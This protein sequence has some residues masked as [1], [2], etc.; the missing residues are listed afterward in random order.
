[1]SQIEKDMPVRALFSVP[2]ALLVMGLALIGLQMGEMLILFADRSNGCSGFACLGA[3]LR[4]SYSWLYMARVLLAVA[5]VLV[6]VTSVRQ[7]HRRGNGSTASRLWPLYFLLILGV[8]LVACVYVDQWMALPQQL[9]GAGHAGQTPPSLGVEMLYLF[10]YTPPLPEIMVALAGWL[11][12]SRLCFSAAKAPRSRSG[13]ALLFALVFAAVSTTVFSWLDI[14]LKLFSGSDYILMAGEYRKMTGVDTGWGIVLGC[15]VLSLPVWAVAYWRD[16]GGRGTRGT[17][18]AA[19]IALILSL[20]SGL[21][22]LIATVVYGG[23]IRGPHDLVRIAREL[24]LAGLVGNALITW[25]S[26]A[27]VRPSA[28]GMLSLANIFR[29]IA[30]AGSVAV[31]AVTLGFVGLVIAAKLNLAGAQPPRH[32]VASQPLLAQSSSPDDGHCASVV[33]A[34]DALWLVGHDDELD[35]IEKVVEDPSAWNLAAGPGHVE[36]QPRPFRT[37]Y[38]GKTVLSRLAPD[39]RFKPVVYFPGRGCLVPVPD[40]DSVLLFTTLRHRGTSSVGNV[41]GTIFQTSDG[42]AHWQEIAGGMFAT[43]SPDV[44]RLGVDYRSAHRVWAWRT[45]YANAGEGALDFG[46]SSDGG[47]TA[48]TL[49]IPDDFRSAAADVAASVPA[50]GRPTLKRDEDYDNRFVTESTPDQ[51]VL[52]LSQ[53]FTYQLPREGGSG[54]RTHYAARTD[55]LVLKRV[56]HAWRAA[57]VKHF[58]D[59]Y[60]GKLVQPRSGPAYA[61]LV[62]PGDRSEVIGRLDDKP[63]RWTTLSSVPSPLWPLADGRVDGFWATDKVIAVDVSTRFRPTWGGSMAISAGGRYYSNDQG[64]HWHKLAIADWPGIFGLDANDRLYFQ[65]YDRGNARRWARAMPFLAYDLAP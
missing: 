60:I 52:W 17:L 39:R 28:R 3:I 32:I 21:V 37:F 45:R 55:A 23:D 13:Q 2:V 36:G 29:L 19:A 20:A 26:C 7:W 8:L 41:P 40:S 33:R 35:S 38:P 15:V 48:E 27:L 12:V 4:N 64:A 47:M 25:L 57:G 65:S 10:L 50:A 34:G 22:C 53:R 58:D 18:S 49:D 11:A 6:A 43:V 14:G 42:G 16:A 9:F 62:R 56:D 24:L 44:A 63:V 30:A 31:V 46:F 1:M 61:V 59:L 51:A 5:A 54:S